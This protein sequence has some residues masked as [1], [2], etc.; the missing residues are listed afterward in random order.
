M[1]AAQFAE[2]QREFNQYGYDPYDSYSGNEWWAVQNGPK[3]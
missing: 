3:L 1:T 2:I